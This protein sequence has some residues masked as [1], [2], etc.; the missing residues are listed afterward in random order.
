MNC[1]TCQYSEPQDKGINCT[2]KIFED[3]GIVFIPE[4]KMHFDCPVHS[5][6]FTIEET[7]YEYKNTYKRDSDDACPVCGRMVRSKSN[8][9]TLI[10]KD[11]ETKKNK[12]RNVCKICYDKLE[13]E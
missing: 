10:T 11:E 8:F 13:T 3:G 12:E 9:R 1:F 2:R 4:K 7:R 5:E 6:N